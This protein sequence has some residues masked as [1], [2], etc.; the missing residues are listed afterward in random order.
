MIN[1]NGLATFDC[2]KCRNI[3]GFYVVTEAVTAQGKKRSHSVRNCV[4]G[5]GGDT[6][7]DVGPDHR[8]SLARL[9]Y[10]MVP[11]LGHGSFVRRGTC[12]LCAYVAT[13]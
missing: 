4:P 3:L 10:L 12:A 8:V 13:S 9:C 1:V 7:D 2:Y 6:T 11:D 5:S